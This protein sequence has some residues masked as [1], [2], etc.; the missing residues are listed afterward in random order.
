MTFYYQT[1]YYICPFQS[2]QPSQTMTSLLGRGRSCSPISIHTALADHDFFF[3]GNPCAHIGFQST[4]PSQTMTA[5]ISNTSDISANTFIQNTYLLSSN[6]FPN[7]YFRIP[8][9]LF[10]C[11]FPSISMCTYGSHQNFTFYTNMYPL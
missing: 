3:H 10:Q 1:V 4:Q 11:G 9:Y 8:Q 5:I 2:T 6:P 7:Q